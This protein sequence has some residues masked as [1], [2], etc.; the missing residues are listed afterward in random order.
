[1]RPSKGELIYEGKAKRVF[2][3]KEDQDLL[4]VEFKDDL[5]AFN[6]VKKGSF[7]GKGA[8]NLEISMLLFE[9]LQAKGVDTHQIAQVGSL[10]LVCRKLEMIPLEVVVRNRLAGST[11]KKLGFK[12]GT[13]ISKPLVEFFWKR[14]ELG[15]P[16]LS[17]DQA[18]LVEA[19]QSKEDLE[20]LKFL[21]LKINSVLAQAF[22][23]VG[24]ELIDFKLEFGRAKN[25]EILL[26][27]EISPDSCRLW[28]IKSGE[29]LDKDRFRQDLGR[30]Q[31]SYF[32]I[33]DRLKQ[34]VR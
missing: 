19:V 14:D 31:E 17:D 16:F 34:G 1:M 33:R 10:E 3:V 29:K 12:D 7:E 11:A 15:D 23:Q 27:D 21:A 9:M 13:V 22:H 8:V 24:L 28:D 30:V 18:L 20:H 26:G 32:E 5:T 25:Q 6:G 4:W 2:Q